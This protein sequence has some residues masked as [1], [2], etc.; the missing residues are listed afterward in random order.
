MSVSLVDIVGLWEHNSL[1]P[2]VSNG[3][4]TNQL[5]G[6]ALEL[7]L[8]AWKPREWGSSG[9]LSELQAELV[10]ALPWED[11]V[12]IIHEALL[13]WAVN[14]F[15]KCGHLELRFLVSLVQGQGEVFSMVKSEGLGP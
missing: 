9:K 4:E 2:V 14:P 8:S 10:T 5:D 15:S 13:N 6:E 1:L 7:G 12:S 11:P 3:L